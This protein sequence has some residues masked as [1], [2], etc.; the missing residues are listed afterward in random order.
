[1]EEPVRSVVVDSLAEARLDR[2]EFTAAVDSNGEVDIESCGVK[3]RRPPWLPEIDLVE[4]VPRLKEAE[5]V[6][7]GDRD[8]RF[9]VAFYPAFRNQS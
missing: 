7:I 4:V 9:H 8:E 5:P 3:R 1:M 6:S 2:V